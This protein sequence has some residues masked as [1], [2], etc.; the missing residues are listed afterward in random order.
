MGSEFM[1]KVDTVISAV[2]QSPD[3]GFLSEEAGIEIDQ[4]KVRVDQNH[5]TTNTKVWAGGDMVTGP[6]TVIDA[7]QAG[8]NAAR[9]I[10]ASIRSAKGE[11]P[12]VAPED[13]GIDIP[14]EVAEPTKQL[15]TPMPEVSP[16]VRRKDFGEV[17]M[18]YTP[19]MAL[20]ET[21]RCMRCDET[22]TRKRLHPHE[23]KRDHH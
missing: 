2:N 15:Q 9:N 21:C 3:L 19:A 10:D 17:R 6:A 11:K 23:V 5:R 7:I 13:E 14:L 12:W 22:M 1:E 18:G 16:S 8:K 20:A 4:G